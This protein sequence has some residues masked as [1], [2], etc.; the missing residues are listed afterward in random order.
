MA[1][2]MN[3]VTKQ[4]EHYLVDLN[5]VE[6]VYRLEHYPVRIVDV[7]ASDG[8]L[9][10]EQQHAIVSRYAIE[11]ARAHMRRGALPPR[12]MQLSGEHLWDAT[13]NLSDRV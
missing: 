7:P 8:T 11:K 13:T 6:G 10:K 9:S 5:V 2:V 12:G 3:T 4:A 1:I